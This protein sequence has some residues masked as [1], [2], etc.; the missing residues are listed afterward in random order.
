MYHELYNAALPNV[1][2]FGCRTPVTP[3][4]AHRPPWL[5]LLSTSPAKYIYF[6]AIYQYSYA[7]LLPLH[8]RVETTLFAIAREELSAGRRGRRRH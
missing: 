1:T 5:R 7:G 8:E 6:I 4:Y 3:S 2:C